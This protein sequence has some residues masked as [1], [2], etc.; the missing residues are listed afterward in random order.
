MRSVVLVAALMGA[1]GCGKRINPAW[2]QQAEN[3]S[4][5][6]CPAAI[7]DAQVQE[8][9]CHASSDCAA[10]PLNKLCNTADNADVCV[11]CLASTDCADPMAPFCTPDHVC[12]PCEHDIE[13]GDAS[14]YCEDGQCKM[15]SSA[16]YASPGGHGDPA[17]CLQTAPCSL[18]DG[19]ALALSGHK[20]LRLIGD[21]TGVTFT[22][23]STIQL[24]SDLRISGVSDPDPQKRII[25]TGAN[26]DPMFRITSGNI[27]LDYLVITGTKG[28][29]IACQGGGFVGRRLH[30]HDLVEDG[31]VPAFSA[32]SACSLTLDA[33]VI[34]GNQHGAIDVSGS[35]DAPF[36]IHNNVFAKNTGGPAVALHGNGRFEYNTVVENHGKDGTS[37]VLCSAADGVRLDMNI[38]ADNGLDNPPT[39]QNE[40][41]KPPT[42]LPAP[43]YQDC[44]LEHGFSNDNVDLKFLRGSDAFT[45]YRLTPNT[46]LSVVNISDVVCSGMSD[47]DLTP[48]PARARCDMGADECADCQLNDPRNTGYQE[49]GMTGN[50]N[51][52][53]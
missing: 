52:G 40:G 27:E 49:Q 4:A 35:A 42:I 8:T 18:A 1:W 36:A 16:F 12:L 44:T 9:A 23:T 14:H 21:A 48:R 46:P 50:G 53:H 32:A 25:L 30:V 7:A 24:T 10:D 5:A 33:S 47:I 34:T 2:C 39:Q 17:M 37:G 20:V 11:E 19:I 43:Q 41:N 6:E 28:T 13:C 3:Q 22:V 15:S 29:A 31:A 51:G 45:Q 26:V 38:L